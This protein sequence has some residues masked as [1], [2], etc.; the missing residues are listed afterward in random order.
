MVVVV[1][2]L[3]RSAEMDHPMQLAALAEMA[4]H[5]VLPGLLR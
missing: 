5:P 3:V 1:A 4:Q 2:A